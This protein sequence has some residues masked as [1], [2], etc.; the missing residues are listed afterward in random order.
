MT[1]GVA[2]AQLS[3]VSLWCLIHIPTDSWPYHSDSTTKEWCIHQILVPRRHTSEPSRAFDPCALQQQDPHRGMLPTIRVLTHPP[4]TSKGMK[5]T[6]RTQLHEAISQWSVSQR[7][8]HVGQERSSMK[9]PK[10][11]GGTSNG[12]AAGKEHTSWEGPRNEEAPADVPKGKSQG[13]RGRSFKG[14]GRH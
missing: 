13:K 5:N 7:G 4:P 2:L 10:K 11:I 6:S 8:C 3:S 12:Q 1:H 14:F 9:G